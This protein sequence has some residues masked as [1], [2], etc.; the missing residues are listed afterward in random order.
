MGIFSVTVKIQELQ[1]SKVLGFQINGRKY[2]DL[3]ASFQDNQ[4]FASI[5]QSQDST[6]ARRIPS[7]EI[8]IDEQWLKIRKSAFNKRVNS[9]LEY[10]SSSHCRQFF[11][12]ELF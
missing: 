9:L 2:P 3:I 7:K 1:L 8:D 12:N 6:F 10:L 4:I 5:G 11:Y